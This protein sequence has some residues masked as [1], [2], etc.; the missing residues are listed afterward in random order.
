[1]RLREELLPNGVPRGPGLGEQA[2]GI[3]VRPLQQLPLFGEMRRSFGAIRLGLLQRVLER[4]LASR[5][6]SRNR[7]EGVPGQDEQQNEEDDQRPD[8]QAAVRSQDVATRATPLRIQR[9]RAKR[10]SRQHAGTNDR[11]TT[12]T[13]RHAILPV[14]AGG[15]ST[16]LVPPYSERR[17]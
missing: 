4:L 16:G 6:R 17:A 5:D 7:A 11:N 13:D 12:H 1:M 8:H 14:R 10:D 15:T 3:A 9:G 2:L